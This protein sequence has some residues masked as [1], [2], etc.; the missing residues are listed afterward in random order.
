M[1][2]KPPLTLMCRLP[3]ARPLDKM[4]T[5]HVPYKW[6]I[7]LSHSQLLPPA[8]LAS[9]VSGEVCATGPL[10][11]LLIPPKCSLRSSLQG[12]CELSEK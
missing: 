12:W 8:T 9:A 1:L 5:P 3:G 7:L 2:V 4:L 11:V 10:H 6:Y